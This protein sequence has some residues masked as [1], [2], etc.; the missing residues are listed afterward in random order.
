MTLIKI[1][2]HLLKHLAYPFVDDTG[3]QERKL[4]LETSSVHGAKRTRGKR[5]CSSGSAK[6]NSVNH[7]QNILR[8]RKYEVGGLSV[9]FVVLLL[10]LRSASFSFSSSSSSCCCYYCSFSSFSSSS[11]SPPPAFSSVSFLSYVSF[12]LFL[13]SLLANTFVCVALQRLNEEFQQKVVVLETDLSESLDELS[14]ALE[15]EKDYEI[16]LNNARRREKSLMTKLRRLEETMR[17]QDEEIKYLVETR[18]T[19]DLS[20]GPSLDVST[21]T[22]RPGYYEERGIDIGISKGIDPRNS[23]RSLSKN[24]DIRNS[25]RS[26]T[27]GDE[28][29]VG[30]RPEKQPPEGVDLLNTASIARK[31]EILGEARRRRTLKSKKDKEKKKEKALDEMPEV[32]QTQKTKKKKKGFFKNLLCCGS[33]KTVESDVYERNDIR[34]V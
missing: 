11:S 28:T 34:R 9:Y 4:R 31:E 23:S 7:V 5:I 10:L 16:S 29:D 32:D 1:C 19:Y 2:A 17:E 21:Q 24:S 8:W 3:N 12:R 15:R 6:N 18:S 25:S 20:Q 27:S 30:K 14:D 33:S 13:N 26:R 22:D